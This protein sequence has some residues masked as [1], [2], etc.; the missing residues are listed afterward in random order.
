MP[1]KIEWTDEVWN[2][3]S[4]CTKVSPGCK[5][6][7]AERMAKR[8]A[9]RCGYPA[10]PHQFDVTLHPDKLDLPLRWRK[11]RLVFVCSMG[12]LFHEDVPTEYIAAVWVAMMR[13]HRHT[14]Q[15]LTKRPG[16]MAEFL[17]GCSEWE[18]WMTHNGTPPKVYGGTGIIVGSDDNW[19]L[20]NAWLGTSVENQAAAD[21]RTPLLLQTPA[22]VRFVSCE[23]L[24][25]KVDLRSNRDWL[26]GPPTCLE[27]GIVLDSRPHPVQPCPNCEGWGY[28]FPRTLDW[29]ICG[30]E[31]GPGARPM[32]LDWARSLV[33]QCK[34]ANVPVFVKQLGAVWAKHA[35]PD[36]DW[37]TTVRQRGDVKGHDMQYWPEDLQVREMPGQE[38]HHDC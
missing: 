13:S 28:Y 2:V 34:S 11:P 23:P 18:G 8:L 26:I 12:D 25:E 5:N 10:A 27:C 29:L 16:R 32:K 20:V 35:E 7:Y 6:C 9:G 36:G 24:L 17:N 4:G 21:E 15:V 14:F 19:P 3:V 33:Q 31:S 1:S 30:G 37:H 38:P 22:A